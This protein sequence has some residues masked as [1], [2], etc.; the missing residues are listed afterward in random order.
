MMGSSRTDPNA[1]R[2]AFVKAS[3]IFGKYT[4]R[5]LSY[6]AENAIAF[7]GLTATIVGLF[8]ISGAFGITVPVIV[9]AAESAVSTLAGM[10]LLG[11]TVALAAAI[12]APETLKKIYKECTE[13]VVTAYKGWVA[14]MFKQKSFDITENELKSKQVKHPE[15]AE[16]KYKTSQTYKEAKEEQYKAFDKK[17]VELELAGIFG[18]RAFKKAA[19]SLCDNAEWLASGVASAP[20]YMYSCLPSFRA[21]SRNENTAVETKQPESPES[22]TVKNSN[23][24]N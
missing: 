9:T 10:P 6:V 7:L 1:A 5:G 3:G 13:W 23:T 11:A 20:K 8:L 12:A 18:K 2:R 4:F 14:N 17:T 22:P 15:Q 21:W 19:N 16:T 24:M